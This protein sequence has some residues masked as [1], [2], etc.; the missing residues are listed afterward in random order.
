[1]KKIFRTLIILLTISLC[2]CQPAPQRNM[3]SSSAESSVAYNSEAPTISSAGEPGDSSEI[4]ENNKTIIPKT[5]SHIEKSASAGYVTL[6]INADVSMP[7]CEALYLYDFHA[8]SEVSE[9]LAK[10]MASVMGEVKSFENDGG[11]SYEFYLSARPDEPYTI[12]LTNRLSLFGHTDNLCPYGENIHSDP[13]AEILTNYTREEAAE[14][15]LEMYGK[16]YDG[17]TTVLEIFSFGATIGLDYYKITAAPIIDNVPVISDKA[18][19][20]FD[21]SEKV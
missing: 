21:V 2:G 20:E 15:C 11:Y 17:N 13:S 19:A 10:S 6:T 3:D 8:T 14:K 12:T 18:C 9:E 16:I 1:M 5:P 4:V 7:D